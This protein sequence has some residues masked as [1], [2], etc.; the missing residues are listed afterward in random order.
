[1]KDIYN[2]IKKNDVSGYVIV[3]IGLFMVVTAANLDMASHFLNWA[4]TFF[5]P[6]HGAL[7]TSVAI[8]VLGS[9]LIYRQQVSYKQ[10]IKES[11]IHNYDN[12]H[13]H[14]LI[15]YRSILNRF[16]L[17]LGFSSPAKLVCIGVVILILAGPFDLAWHT[18]FGLDGLLSPSHT[19]FR[20]GEA[21]AG[22]GALWGIVTTSGVTN[23]KPNNNDDKGKAI[24]MSQ[25]NHQIDKVSADNSDSCANPPTNGNSNSRLNHYHRLYPLFIVISVAAL[26]RT[27]AGFTGMVTLPFSNTVYFNFNPN[28]FLAVYIASICFPFFTSIMLFCSF[29]LGNYNFD[30]SLRGVKARIVQWRAKFGI[31]TSTGFAYMLITIFTT[32]LPN[33]FLVPSIPWYVLNIIPIIAVDVLLTLVYANPFS[34]NTNKRIV[35]YSA[36]AILGL[37]SIT[38]QYPYVAITYSELIPPH[39][40]LRPDNIS[41]IYLKT[42]A[43]VWP[44]LIVP[45]IA[46]GIFGIIV[47][48]KI[49][50]YKAQPRPIKSKLT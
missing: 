14:E 25:V 39:Q 5:S 31:L 12:H 19:L 29:K 35:K 6:A 45:S 47:G 30:D 48:S 34:S 16:N 40:V 42:M 13:K 37:I 2:K 3:S 1:M 32:F 23:Y 26:W 44:W 10:Q 41:M 27:A 11:S 21:I 18:A 8:M 22:I 17:F 28:P 33:R 7:Y 50:A 20:I 49:L 9:I 38:L 15:V 4:E 43:E 46:G 24:D 36:G